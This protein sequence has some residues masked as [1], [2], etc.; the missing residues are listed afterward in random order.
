M[1]LHRKLKILV[2]CLRRHLLSQGLSVIRCLEEWR[3]GR[4]GLIAQW[5]PADAFPIAGG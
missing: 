1:R 3:F 2:V 4:G 5:N